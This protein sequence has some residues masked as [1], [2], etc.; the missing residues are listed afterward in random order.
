MAVNL[1]TTN[2]A[3]LHQQ[4]QMAQQAVRPAGLIRGESQPIDRGVIIPSPE[5]AQKVPFSPEELLSISYMI[6][7]PKLTD[8]QT[9]TLQILIDLYSKIIHPQFNPLK[10]LFI[11]IIS[12]LMKLQQKVDHKHNGRDYQ[13][14]LERLSKQ[15]KDS[16][17]LECLSIEN[18]CFQ[19][20]NLF[21]FYFLTHDREYV[22]HFIQF[23]TTLLEIS[24]NI[25]ASNAK[26]YKDALQKKIQLLIYCLSSKDLFPLILKP[27]NHSQPS[28]F[29]NKE[30]VDLFNKVLRIFSKGLEAHDDY[31][32]AYIKNAPSEIAQLAGFQRLKKTLQTNINQIQA[33]VNS[34]KS[35]S[36]VIKL[37]TFQKCD[38]LDQNA[39]N[40]YNQLLKGLIAEGE[41]LN[42]CYYAT[43]KNIHGAW[44][45]LSE[46]V[47][48]HLHSHYEFFHDTWNETF[49]SYVNDNY[50]PLR[51]ILADLE[52]KQQEIDKDYPL[53]QKALE[54]L[55]VK[56]PKE[57][58]SY[59]VKELDHYFQCLTKDIAKLYQFTEDK[60]MIL[61]IG[62]LS[63]CVSKMQQHTLSLSGLKQTESLKLIINTQSLITCLYKPSGEFSVLHTAF[64]RHSKAAPF[65]SKINISFKNLND[66]L[67]QTK[68]L[69]GTFH[70][71]CN[72][73]LGNKQELD[74]H[75]LTFINERLEIIRTHAQHLDLVPFEVFDKEIF[76][77]LNCQDKALDP[78]YRETFK[79]NLNILKEVTKLFRSTPPLRDN[80][81]ALLFANKMAAFAE[82]NTYESELMLNRDSYED[83]AKY[84]NT[85][86]YKIALTQAIDQN[87][88][89]EIFISQT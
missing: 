25:N 44:Q 69:R 48:P 83:L 80:E 32:Q 71:F 81:S 87:K 67:E 49:D 8:Q 61:Y 84:F 72:K 65:I 64:N 22:D 38:A 76:S 58:R 17:A 63:Y 18:L 75:F 86:D 31:H 9:E 54:T 82:L 45:A 46:K 29:L 5:T 41:K 20:F 50:L 4:A 39:F 52:S 68:K 30:M 3:T 34:F 23:L 42:N 26:P 47:P 16:G 85:A 15:V 73:R 24:D 62:D 13:T 11:D 12:H 78:F 59:F 6:T 21:N 56:R 2:Q 74:N 66:A 40:N 19:Q 14:H 1:T 60:Q 37:A 33:G 89:T 43:L 79:K 57:F 10:L 88:S 35:S 7:P 27:Q 77:S 51:F 36:F 70:V 53:A 55:I 28:L